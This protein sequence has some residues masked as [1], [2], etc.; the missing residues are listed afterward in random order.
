[1]D[2]GA[3]GAVLQRHASHGA[4]FLSFFAESDGSGP[5]REG[6]HNIMSFDANNPHHGAAQLREA[7][8]DL[9]R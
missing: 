6:V 3:L 9:M 7:V 1:M 5:W 4:R 8:R 2:A